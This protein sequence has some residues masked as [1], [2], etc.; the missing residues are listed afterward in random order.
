LDQGDPSVDRRNLIAT[1]HRG[2]R[3]AESVRGP[4]QL[5]SDEHATRLVAIVRRIAVAVRG[6]FLAMA[7]LAMVVDMQMRPSPA[8]AGCRLAVRMMPATPQHR[9]QSDQQAQDG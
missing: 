2:L 1:K 4:R 9:V 6:Q 8:V 3:F 5:A 7:E